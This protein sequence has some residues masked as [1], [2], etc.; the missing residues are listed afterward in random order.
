MVD[1]RAVVDQA[2]QV[3][4]ELR[5]FVTTS[6]GIAEGLGLVDRALPVSTLLGQHIYNNEWLADPTSPAI[7]VGTADMVGSRLRI[8]GYRVSHKIRPS[9]AARVGTDV[10]VVLD[11]A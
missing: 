11:E 8:G 9:H 10:L 1:R 6:R 2:T 4:N 5:E 7:V 3:A